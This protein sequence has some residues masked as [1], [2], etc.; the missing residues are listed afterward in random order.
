MS[1]GRIWR[2][3]S[4]LSV[5]SWLTRQITAR[6]YILLWTF[7]ISSTI[8]FVQ[9]EKGRIDGIHTT[10]VYSDRIYAPPPSSIMTV[11]EQSNPPTHAHI[12]DVVAG[13]EML[14]VSLV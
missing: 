9:N 3:V 11:E 12:V 1:M 2:G 6:Y 13:V 8:I 7:Y 4:G 14:N 5:V 10:C